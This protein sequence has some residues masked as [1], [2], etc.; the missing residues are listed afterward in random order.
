LKK[1]KTKK[2]KK[3][4]K[5]EKEVKNKIVKMFS[6]LQ[7]KV[8]YLRIMMQSQ[9]YFFKLLQSQNEEIFW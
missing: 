1:R 7:I 8:S 3:K 6:P 2:E 4:R 5:R 9:F